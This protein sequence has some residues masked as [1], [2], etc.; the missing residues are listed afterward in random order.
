MLIL[1]DLDGTLVDPFVGIAMS[2]RHAFT[3]V[4]VAVPSDDVIRTMIGPPFEDALS[5][6]GVAPER[7]LETLAHYREM[8]NGQNAMFEATA[9]DGIASVLEE[10]RS[11]GHELAVATSKPTPSAERVLAHFGLAEYFHFV[12]GATFDGTRRTKED[13]VAHVLASCATRPAVMVG[14][15][16]YDVI[17]AR[18]HALTSVAVTWGY[19]EDG[20]FDAHPPDHAAD[21]PSAL[22]SLLRSL[23]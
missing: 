7:V 5:R 13:V 3:Q 14:D 1:F 18:T 6:L 4:G 10:L 19:A 20:E 12:G 22:L 9:Y 23:A 21:T 15:R 2:L 17:G 8:Y 16:R 11:D